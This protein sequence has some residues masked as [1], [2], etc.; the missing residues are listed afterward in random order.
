MANTNQ[1]TSKVQ[2]LFPEFDIG[3]F[4]S[5]TVQAIINNLSEDLSGNP[6]NMDLAELIKFGDVTSLSTL[7]QEATLVGEIRAKQ[8]GIIAGLPIAAFI[9]IWLLFS[10]ARSKIW[11]IRKSR[12]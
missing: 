5:F 12:R 3:L 8:E 10:L 1:I 2:N 9:F 7:P 11:F 4:D 6:T